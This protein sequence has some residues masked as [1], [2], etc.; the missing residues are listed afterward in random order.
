MVVTEPLKLYRLDWLDNVTVHD[1]S[2]TALTDLLSDPY[3]DDLSEVLQARYNESTLEPDIAGP[4]QFY[5]FTHYAEQW[6]ETN[7]LADGERCDSLLR[8]PALRTWMRRFYRLPSSYDDRAL[9][10][11]NVG[12]TSFILAVRSPRYSTSTLP[13]QVLKLIKPRHIR[14][15]SIT[16]ALEEMLEIYR[17]EHFK[18]FL[19]EYICDEPIDPLPGEPVVRRRFLA[20]KYVPG[21]TLRKKVE[22][23]ART[24][25]RDRADAC[26][27]LAET[28][29]ANVGGHLHSLKVTLG[30]PHLDLSPENIILNPATDSVCLLD[31]GFNH[32][33]R[34]VAKTSPRIVKR[35]ARYVA[36]ELKEQG[37]EAGA[38]TADAYSLG[39][40]LL[41]LLACADPALMKCTEKEFLD[42][43]SDSPESLLDRVRHVHFGTGA[44]LEAML[45]ANPETRI[46]ERR[47]RDDVYRRL[48]D[49]LL[50]SIDE[51]QAHLEHAWMPWWK[52]VAAVTDVD[53]VSDPSGS[54]VTSL[55]VAA[56]SLIVGRHV[57]A[58]CRR[59]SWAV[60]LYLLWA[61]TTSLQAHW[62]SNWNVSWPGWV[63]GFTFTFVATKYYLSVFSGISASGLSPMTEWWMRL[64]ALSFGPFILYAF[65][66]DLTSYAACCAWGMFIV[67]VNNLLSLRLARTAE[68]E[69][70]RV[71]LKTPRPVAQAGFI[72]FFAR[73]AILTGAYCVML[74][75]IHIG[76][77][78]GQLN[79]VAFYALIVVALNVK[80]FFQNCWSDAPTIRSGLTWLYHN[81]RRARG[82]TETQRARAD[83]PPNLSSVSVSL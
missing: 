32:V 52:R 71:G 66:V 58:A 75:G 51:F 24:T 64:N 31:F 25:G 76:I 79:D 40:I 78:S 69:I 8:E 60:C 21:P 27:E 6:G 5:Y 81:L 82:Y 42:R 56:R 59:L 11:L 15:A 29:A 28:I 4:L 55:L 20:M 48:T 33:L 49:D 36:P 70:E 53:P 62:N 83:I 50:V 17:I 46:F 14:H 39:L 45:D 7:D 13:D 41:E 30:K 74:A 63:V 1:E 65:A 26:V 19:P 73:W 54:S 38:A 72:K 3:A 34:G 44:L 35:A 18:R 77:R 61:S 80:M 16:G 37:L 22:A 23:L 67:F 12:T 47:G 68:A 9:T 10:L 43:I 2:L 57:L